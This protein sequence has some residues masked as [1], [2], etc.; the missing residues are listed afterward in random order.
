[1]KAEDD[2]NGNA[3]YESLFERDRRLRTLVS[4]LPGV[5]YRCKNN[6]NWDMQFISDGCLKITGYTAEQFCNPK[7]GIT[8]GEIIHPEDREN[9]WDTIQKANQNKEQFHVNYRILN[10]DKEIRWIS[11]TGIGIKKGN[12]KIQYVEGFIQDITAQM[13][14]GNTLEIRKRALDATASGLI[15]A[16]AKLNRFPIIY[17]N[18]AFEQITGYT[19]QEVMGLNCDFLQNDD[20]HQK[21]I[22]TISKALRSGKSCHV[23]L[24]NYKKDGSMFWNEL[25]ITPVRNKVGELTHFIG[26]QNDITTKKNLELLHQAK[27]DLL[28]MVIKRRPLQETTK[29]IQQILEQQ[30]PNANIALMIFNKQK[31]SLEKV[32]SPNLPKEFSEMLENVSVEPNSCSCAV[33]AYFK[34]KEIAENILEDP[35]WLKF[36]DPLVKSGMN[37]CWSYPMLDAEDKILGVLSV[38]HQHPG[39][40]GKANEALIEELASLASVAIEQTNIREQLQDNIEQ[41]ALYSKGLEKEVAER[42]KDLK[43]AFKELEVSNFELIGQTKEAKAAEIR[44]ETSEAMLMEIAKKFPKGVIL[45]VDDNMCINFMEGTELRGLQEQV[46]RTENK[47]IDELKSFS[48]KRKTLLKKYVQRTLAGEHLSFETKYRN[49]IYGVNTTPLSVDNGNITHALLVLLNISK[50]KENERKI[51]ENLKK[52]RELSEL[53]SRFITTAS[54]EFRTP[55]SVI[56]SSATLIEKL[57]MPGKEER[58]LVHL[59]R[60][61]SN[62]QHLGVVLNDFLSLSKLE[63]GKTTAEFKKF[64]LVAFS[65]S[66]IEEIETHKKHG[67]VII[68]EHNLPKTE[69]LLDSKLMHHILLNL[70]SNAV[71]YSPKNK[72]ITLKIE[73]EAQKIS[74]WVIDEGI[75]IP[76][77]E[78]QHLFQRFFRAKNSL[79]ISGTGLGL[80]IV[81]QYVELMNGELS[82]ESKENV[83]ST[84]KMVFPQ[85]HWKL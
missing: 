77:S 28:E 20:R 41:L 12:K 36:R 63:E 44:A 4:N 38:F 21:E 37:S 3:I 54:H 30:I 49:N 60:I 9:V 13:E 58:R 8:W 22:E 71:K 2:F 33:S 52:E 14:A 67:Q 79:N 81:K 72:Q 5:V 65:R 83:G 51:F 1:M 78:Q 76:E 75:G 42:T 40:P 85:K 16:D 24:R 69:V 74:I 80:H 61:R 47:K 43:E 64:D 29:R 18:N 66:V 46:S 57:N 50:R 82:F 11:E 15:I 27:S 32:T 62:V 59:H 56:L 25:S 55:L 7:S 19:S 35:S 23:V 26:T 31:N 73:S 70:L 68:F 17:V 10:I 45:L 39:I 34:R 6:R 53:K 48:D 84:F